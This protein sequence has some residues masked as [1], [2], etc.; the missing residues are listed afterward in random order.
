MNPPQLYLYSKMSGFSEDS[1]CT[2]KTK[3]MYII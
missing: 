1:C 3:S 2:D